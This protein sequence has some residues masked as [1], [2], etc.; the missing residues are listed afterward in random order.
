MLTS[1][2]W[3]SG[4]LVDK[5]NKFRNLA[6]LLMSAELLLATAGT[7]AFSQEQGGAHFVSCVFASIFAASGLYV[8]FTN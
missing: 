4:V 1:S 7:F 2:N 3:K 8:A 5:E 6:V